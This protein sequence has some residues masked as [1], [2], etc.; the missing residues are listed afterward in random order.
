MAARVI[1]RVR[2]SRFMPEELPDLISTRMTLIERLKDWEDQE[3]WRQFFDTYWKLIYSVARKSGLSQQDA[4]DVV[5][6]TVICVS[7]NIRNFKAD[8]SFGSFRAWL[9]RMT[10][11]RVMNRTNRRPPEEAFRF[12]KNHGPSQ[13]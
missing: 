10:R 5:Q 6:E 2:I 3:S 4:E 12:H 1:H 11:W 13:D 8:S 9:L 7:K